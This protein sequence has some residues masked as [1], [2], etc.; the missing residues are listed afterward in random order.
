LGPGWEEGVR[1]VQSAMFAAAAPLA[2]AGA[3]ADLL[4]GVGVAIRRTA[5]VALITGV[6]LS[7]GYLGLATVLLTGLWSDPLG[8]LVK[9]L[10]VIVLH[11][12]ALAILDER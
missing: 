2:A 5:K 3:I 8:S 10:P 9:V 7:V 6:A 11:L 4:I 12:V 1:L